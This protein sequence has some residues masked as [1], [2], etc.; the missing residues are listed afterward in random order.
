[1]AITPLPVPPSTLSPESFATDAD[2]FLAAL[3]AFATE[4]NAAGTA[5]GL[6][7]VAASSTSLTIGTGSKSLT[8]SAGCVFVPGMEIF[9]ASTASPANKMTC[10]VTTYNNGTGAMVV[11]AASVS[12][13]GTFAA[14]SI[15][16]ASTVNFD[17]QTF[18]NLI[19]AGK[20]TESIYALS[21]T[22]IDPANGSVQTK[23]LSANTTLTE[24]I[25]DGQSVVLILTAGGYTVTWPT[26][27]WRWG[28]AP[29]L[30][31]TGKSHVVL[32]QVGG[33][34]YGVLAGTST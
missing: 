28:A 12:G 19:L 17:G 30:S 25:A 26:V 16:P 4:L 10:T 34:L 9:I 31:P 18:S 24:S 20:I 33:L 6:T 15:G 21:G 1:M 14:W 2:T 3:P 22:V 23:T 29:T 7:L 11:N 27:A 5:A 8:A 32:Y 13:S